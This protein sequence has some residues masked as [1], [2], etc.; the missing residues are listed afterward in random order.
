MY[1]AEERLM[2]TLRYLATGTSM[3]QL[4]YDWC[5][6]VSS[7]SAIIPEACEAISTQLRDDY[8]KTPTTAA[9][10]EAISMQLEENWNFPNAI[11]KF[12]LI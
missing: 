6:S 1:S 2:V 8:L 4:H 9:E 11:G 5:I 3:T 7:L 12:D 10:W